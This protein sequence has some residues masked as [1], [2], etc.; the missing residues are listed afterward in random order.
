MSKCSGGVVE[1][2]NNINRQAQDKKMSVFGRE[3]GEGPMTPEDNLEILGITSGAN[4]VIMQ[5][6]Q[7]PQNPS[8]LVF[9]LSALRLDG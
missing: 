4:P 6:D 1:R 5:A 7:K 9:T 2:N 3:A 8:G